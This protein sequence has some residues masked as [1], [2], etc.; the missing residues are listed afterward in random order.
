MAIRSKDINRELQIIDDTARITDEDRKTGAKIIILKSMLKAMG[1]M[2][3][4]FRDYRNNQVLIM[5]K[6]GIELNTQEDTKEESK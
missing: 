4:L 2:V 3:K 1:L 5:K 6:M